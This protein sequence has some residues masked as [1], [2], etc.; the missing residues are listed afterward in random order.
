MI[1]TFEPL[2]SFGHHVFKL[3]VK[4]ERNRAIRCRV[5]DDLAHFRREIFQGVAVPRKDLRGAWIKL[6]Q[7]WRGLLFSFF[8]LGVTV[9]AETGMT[10]HSQR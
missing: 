1:L 8:S 10:V 7:T 4:F 3:C 2:W 6:H 5:I 9:N